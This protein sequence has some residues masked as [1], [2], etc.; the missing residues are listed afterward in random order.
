MAR[1]VPWVVALACGLMLLSL[2]VDPAL[3]EKRV[4]LVIGN[5]A[6]QNV[7]KLDNPVNDAV[8]I[9]EMFRAAG[10]EVILKL[11]V[12]NLGFKRALRDFETI[13]EQADLAAVYFAGHGIE[14]S[15]INYLIPIDASLQRDSDAQDE[16]VDLERIFRSF[17]GEQTG[18]H[19]HLVFLDACRDNPFQKNMKRRVAALRSGPARGGLGAIEIFDAETLVAYAAKAGSTAEDGADGHSPY[20]KALLKYLPEPGIDIRIALGRVRDE[21][22]KNTSTHQEP[23]YYGSLGGAE[24]SLIPGQKGASAAAVSN[25]DLAIQHDYE[26]AERV[27]T[28]NAWKSF[29]RAHPD[30]LY[31]EY[32]NAQLVKLT[33]PPP[34]DAPQSKSDAQRNWDRIKDSGDPAALREFIE[35]FSSSPLALIAKQ[36]LDLILERAATQRREEEERLK[37]AAEGARQRA[38]R[39]AAQQRREDE[40]RRAKAATEAERQRL[41]REIAQ[42]R[43]EEGRRANAAIEAERQRAEAAAKAAEA[44]LVRSAQGELNRIGCFAG[45]EDGTLNQATRDAIQHYRSKR[46]Q[47]NGDIK[48]TAGFI[49]ELRGQVKFESCIAAPKQE[50]P[51]PIARDKNRRKHEEEREAK[52]PPHETHPKHEETHPKHEAREPQREP[53][54]RARSEA[55]VAP[56]H[57]RVVSPEPRGGTSGGIHMMTGVGN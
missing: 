15:G 1:F 39:E 53:A 3:A 17:G 40:E 55:A 27:G 50:K 2:A 6:Y 10:F 11:D 29:L 24:I 8:S 7:P 47:P 28:P 42:R 18:H 41:E 20:A 44:D 45:R 46:G 16:A 52:V 21:V 4:A 23:F 33:L 22:V 19:V 38:E 51:E 31:A 49:S 35:R 9:K 32:A 30:G 12:G 43:E 54:P 26:A 13:A 25:L 48:I 57:Y 5:S 14:I 56:Q 36:Q 37:A 34:P